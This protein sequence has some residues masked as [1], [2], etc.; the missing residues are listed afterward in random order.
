MNFQRKSLDDLLYGQQID[1]VP[2]IPKTKSP[3]KDFP[4]KEHFDG[5]LRS[6]MADLSLWREKGYDR[7]SV[8]GAN[9]L[10]VFDFDSESAFKQFWDKPVEKV[11]TETFTVKTSRGY[12]VWFKDS[13]A[14]FIQ[15]SLDFR[16]TLEAELLISHHLASC[17]NNLHPSGFV[18]QGPL[19]TGKVAVKL[20]FTKMILERLDS[21][22]YSG[23]TRQSIKAIMKGV[24]LGQRN[25]AGFKYARYLL[26]RIELDIQAT[27]CELQRWNQFNSPPLSAQE[28]QTILES[29]L[30]YSPIKQRALIQADGSV[31]VKVENGRA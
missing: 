29:A 6:K 22:G 9:D 3:V 30:K 8:C 2:T 26:D 17:P 14:N 28:L 31:S 24:P 1:L 19:G 7:A 20:G 12:S 4:L 25:N 10:V 18:Y 5:V 15:T 13:E 21:L 23:K 16:P 27:L 11:A